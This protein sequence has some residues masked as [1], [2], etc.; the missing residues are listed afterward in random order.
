MTASKF[1]PECLP[2]FTHQAS[3]RQRTGGVVCSIQIAQQ[4]G[5]PVGM[6]PAHIST[7]GC[8]QPYEGHNFQC[9]YL[10]REPLHSSLIGSRQ[11]AGLEHL[12]RHPDQANRLQN[13]RHKLFHPGQRSAPTRSSNTD[14]ALP[15]GPQ[16]IWDTRLGN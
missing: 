2:C 3:H 10:H 6:G 5:Q 16:T 7:D 13:L 15:M 9:H 11:R 8:Q 14:T 4:A 1:S 12:I